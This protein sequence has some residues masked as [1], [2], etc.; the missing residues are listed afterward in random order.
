MQTIHNCLNEEDY[1]YIPQVSGKCVQSQCHTGYLMFQ[2][3]TIIFYGGV[4]VHVETDVVDGEGHILTHR[5]SS[6]EGCSGCGGRCGSGCSHF[7]CRNSG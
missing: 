3:H 2:L 5:C 4:A 1:D 6:R 7:S